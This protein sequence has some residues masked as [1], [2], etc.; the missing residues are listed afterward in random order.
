M[1][2]NK[3]IYI[4]FFLS[5]FL[6]VMIDFVLN[7]Y[8]NKDL[9]SFVYN[10]VYVN[11]EKSN[12]NTFGDPLDRKWAEKILDGGYIVF[13]RHTQR[14]KRFMSTGIYDLLE[15]EVHQNGID[16]TRYAENDY[17]ADAVCLTD[18]GKIQAKAI[19]EF[20]KKIN[21]PVGIIFTSP[22]CRARRTAENIFGHYDQIK[23]DLWHT[24]VHYY[25]TKEFRF[26][27]LRKVFS[28]MPVKVG[29]NTIITAHGNVIMPELFDNPL[30]KNLDIEQAGMIILSKKD[31]NL[32]IEHSFE[33]FDQFIRSLY[34]RN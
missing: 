23:K 13:I 7:L 30:Q 33:T 14:N 26:K 17:F 11:Q 10:K 8:S 18:E 3:T 15:A 27:S 9:K 22:S 5:L 2:Y 19:G 16:G 28:E 4:I 1:K 12:N 6:L 29:K 31:D 24:G 21:F 34:V 32:Q 20:L 25:E